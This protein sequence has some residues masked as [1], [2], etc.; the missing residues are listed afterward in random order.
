MIA[1][2]TVEARDG[3]YDH[4][5]AY[6][7]EVRG[8]A[9][10]LDDRRRASYLF[11]L[12]YAY[13]ET[14]DYEAA[15][16]TGYAALSLFAAMQADAETAALENDMALAFLKLGNLSRADE[17]VASARPRFEAL[18]DARWL[19][20]IA[21]TEA[22]IALAGSSL[23]RRRPSPSRRSRARADGQSEG[24][25]RCAHDPRPDP[26]AARRRRGRRR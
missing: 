23:E 9:E 16:R 5:L 8:L 1:L 13:R 20:H 12:A 15:V 22:Q 6:L 7:S 10:Q 25:H 21:D 24:A 3:E 26:E 17:L 14:A 4:A 2:A 18:G 11:D 19:A